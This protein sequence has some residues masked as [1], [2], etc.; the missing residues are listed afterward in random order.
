MISNLSIVYSFIIS[1][2][3]VLF[4]KVYE[5]VNYKEY[6]TSEYIKIFIITL[7]SSISTFYIK[8][9]LNPFFTKMFNSSS[10]HGGNV[11]PPNPIN[12]NTLN[13]PNMLGNTVLP[14]LNMNFNS[15]KPTF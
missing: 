5:K 4:L 14:P 8:S 6:E 10:I 12:N 2:I 15:G 1:S 9:F 3:T 7:L 11:M 13:I